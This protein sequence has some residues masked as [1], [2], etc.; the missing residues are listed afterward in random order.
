MAKGVMR[1]YLFARIWGATP[2]WRREKGEERVESGIFPW[3]LDLE[4]VMYLWVVQAHPYDIENVNQTTIPWDIG[5]F[6][7]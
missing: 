5:F 6:F 1:I 4:T 7:D 3:H 2:F